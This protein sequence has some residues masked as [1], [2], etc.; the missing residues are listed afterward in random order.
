MTSFSLALSFSDGVLID[1]QEEENEENAP[2]RAFHTAN[3]YQNTMYVFGGM[4]QGENFSDDLFVLTLGIIPR[5]HVLIMNIDTLEWKLC[6]TIRGP[7]ARALHASAVHEGKLY[8]FGGVYRQNGIDKAFDDFYVLE[9]GNH[10]FCF[11]V[12][13]LKKR[14][15]NGS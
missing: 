12:F 3:V 15:C 13:L 14:L 7:S 6:K 1:P 2:L 5:L 4:K 10:H 11:F 9:L 8:I